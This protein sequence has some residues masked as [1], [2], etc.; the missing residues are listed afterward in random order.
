MSVSA[1]SVDTRTAPANR[2]SVLDLQVVPYL[3]QQGCKHILGVFPLENTLINQACPATASAQ[4]R[5]RE[6][7]GTL[8]RRF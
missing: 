2:S 7:M 4:R 1:H 8:C 6:H 5:A 3:A